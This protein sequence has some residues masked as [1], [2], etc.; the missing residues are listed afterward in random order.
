MKD[1]PKKSLQEQIAAEVLDPEVMKPIFLQAVKWEIDAFDHAST[2]KCFLAT[3]KDWKELEWFSN[4]G[5]IVAYSDN[6]QKFRRKLLLF[7]IRSIPRNYRKNA[8][9][10]AGCVPARA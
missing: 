5:Y 3:H 4:K 2:R 9:S 7:I 6:Q 10:S 8:A 1:F